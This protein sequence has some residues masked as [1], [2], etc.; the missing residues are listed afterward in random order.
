MFSRQMSRWLA[1]AALLSSFLGA[2]ADAAPPS[3]LVSGWGTR[4]NFVVG[5][6]VQIAG[7][8]SVKGQF[9]IVIDL[10][11]GTHNSCRYHRFYNGKIVGSAAVFFGYGR[12]V[13][14]TGAWYTSHNQFSVVDNGWPGAGLDTIDVNF[15]GAGGVAVPGGF[16]SSGD[17]VVLP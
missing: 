12:C 15:L 16:I 10:P 3:G 8:G 17:F 5:G 4:S 13:T 11:D 14:S 7:D 9:T 6:E 1:G 2:A